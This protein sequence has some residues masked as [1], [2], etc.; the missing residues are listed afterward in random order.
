MYENFMA[1]CKREMWLRKMSNG[2]LAQQTGYKKSTI[3]A[4][5]CDIPGREK[6]RHVAEAIAAALQ[7]EI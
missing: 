2:D 6:S 1:D 7:M 5:F 4:F 3:D